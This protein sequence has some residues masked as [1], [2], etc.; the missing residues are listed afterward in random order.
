MVRRSDRRPDR[1][2][3]LFDGHEHFAGLRTFGRAD[4][5]LLLQNV[6]DTAGAGEADP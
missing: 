5:P 1:V 6:H 3:Q 2:L 4:Y